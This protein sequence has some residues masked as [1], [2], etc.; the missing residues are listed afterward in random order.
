MATVEAAIALAALVAVLVLCAGALLAVS[1]QVRCVDAA[2]EAARLAARG[3]GAKAVAAGQ[4]V[5]PPHATVE[6]RTEGELV[7]A[8]VRVRAPLL[9]LTLHAEAVAVREPGETS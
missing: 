5:A 7:T 4:R 1:A 2:R 9:P 8:V 6:V 3:E